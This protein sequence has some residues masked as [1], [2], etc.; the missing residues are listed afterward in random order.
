M[1]APLRFAVHTQ[2]IKST[3]FPIVAQGQ[4]RQRCARKWVQR[5]GSGDIQNIQKHLQGFSY[6]ISPNCSHTQNA[7]TEGIELEDL[8]FVSSLKTITC[9]QFVI[10]KPME[11]VKHCSSSL[12]FSLK[13]E[14]RVLAFQTVI[15]SFSCHG[16]HLKFEIALCRTYSCA[17]QI[18]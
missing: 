12:I 15:D 16:I 11:E 13:M 5:Q 6:V 10:K 14:G 8:L 1:Q 7:Q 4:R 2:R 17:F 3:S 18:S 9:A